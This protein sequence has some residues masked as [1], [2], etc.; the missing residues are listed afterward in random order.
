MGDLI[1]LSNLSRP[2]RL[3]ELSNATQM[4]SRTLAENTRSKY[5]L[6]AFASFPEFLGR[7]GILSQV[8]PNKVVHNV[9][10]PWGLSPRPAAMLAAFLSV[11]ADGQARGAV[12]L[13]YDP[14]ACGISHRSPN[15]SSGPS[16]FAA[17]TG[18][19]REC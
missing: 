15:P 7:R 5:I 10:L 11:I 6:C 13:G 17:G 8:G 14:S 4:A 16:F 18:P 3:I 9:Q 1:L 19:C 2:L 12:E